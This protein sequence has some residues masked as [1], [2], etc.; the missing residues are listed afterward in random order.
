M[1]SRRISKRMT[2]LLVSF[3][4]A[5]AVIIGIFIMKYAKG[6]I[7]YEEKLENFASENSSL[8]K[9][10][11]VFIGDSIT[12]GY[13]LNRH[14]RD[15]KLKTYNRGLSGDTTDWLTTRLQ[16]SLFD[17]V[18]TQVVLMIGTNDINSG[19]S[20]EE[21]AAN[22]EHIL[23]LIASNLPNAKVCCISIIPQNTEYSQ[24]A[25]ENNLRIKETNKK[26]EVIAQSFGYEYVNLFDRLTDENGLLKRKYSSDG[27]HLNSKG[28]RV[29]TEAMKEFWI[30]DTS[31]PQT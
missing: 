5:V 15:L 14:Y 9:N 12:A 16:I 23:S 28:Y 26:I 11:I 3:F 10:Q 24:S 22:Y 1:R 27:L 17:L 4:L 25:S 21:I 29:W 6:T 19:K 2:A 18:P 7:T 31:Q 20:A 8:E 30:Y 13:R